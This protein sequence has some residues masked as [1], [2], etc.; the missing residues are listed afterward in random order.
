MA[1]IALSLRWMVKN[2][3]QTLYTQYCALYPHL[4][5]STTSAILVTKRTSTNVHEQT[6]EPRNFRPLERKLSDRTL[7]TVHSVWK[8]EGLR[9]WLQFFS[10][11]LKLYVSY[12]ECSINSAVTTSFHTLVSAIPIRQSILCLDKKYTFGNN[13]PFIPTIK[14]IYGRISMKTPLKMAELLI[15]T[16]TLKTI[17]SSIWRNH[18]LFR[19]CSVYTTIHNELNA[20][21]ATTTK[22]IELILAPTL[23]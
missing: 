5:R 14:K 23:A 4:N 19:G 21:E 22:I 10:F 7:S 3:I 16:R 17:N 20:H 11:E 6:I 9:I 15:L 2:H 12:V 18:Y 8:I 1:C 13:W